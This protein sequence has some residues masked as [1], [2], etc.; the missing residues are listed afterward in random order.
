MMLVGYRGV[1]ISNSEPSKRPGAFG[2]GK[3]EFR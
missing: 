3:R 2:A 1:V